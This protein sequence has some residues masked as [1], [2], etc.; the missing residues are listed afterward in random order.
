MHLYEPMLPF[1]YLHISTGL[2]WRI[3]LLLALLLI[4]PFLAGCRHHSSDLAAAS[5]ASLTLSS[6]SLHDGRVPKEFTCDG[7]DKSPL[8]DWTTAPSGTETLALTVTDP[9]APGGTFK[10]WVIYNLPA[11]TTGLPEGV[12]KLG[13]LA[14]GSRQGKT[15]FGKVGYGGPCPPAGK[16]HHYMFT[17]YALDT[18]VEVPAGAPYSHVESAMQ[19]HVLARGE[20]TASYGR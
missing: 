8:L 18:Q 13:Q 9:D 6:S 7:E 16:P 12:P 15:D 11:N 19:G 5:G 1:R 2:M 17:L 3:L 14:N 10:H 4:A 20:L